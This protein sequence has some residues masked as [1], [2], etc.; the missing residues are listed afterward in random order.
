MI[1][2]TILTVS[3]RSADQVREDVT[4]PLVV[5]RLRAAGFDVS[6]PRVIPDG[7]DSVRTALTDVLATSVD[8][9]LTLGGTGIGPRDQTPEG[10]APLLAAELP[11]IIEEL[12]RVGLRTVP[13][14]VL[15]RGLA[16]IAKTPGGRAVI[17]NLPGSRGAAEDGLAVLVPLIPHIVDQLSGG[18][19]P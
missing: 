2:G 14:A 10:T 8:F 3:D 17:V 7:D 11:G 19:H 15:S 6:E 18:D 9:V 16:G 12:R 1:R 4:G 5:S 13:T